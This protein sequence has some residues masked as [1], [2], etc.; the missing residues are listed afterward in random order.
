MNY[1]FSIIFVYNINIILIIVL[2][3]ICCNNTTKKIIIKNFLI[4]FKKEQKQ[5]KKDFSKY[6]Y[7]YSS[8]NY[9]IKLAFQN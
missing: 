6:T 5:I 1:L 8:I 9:Y 7:F 2:L 3:F 4:T